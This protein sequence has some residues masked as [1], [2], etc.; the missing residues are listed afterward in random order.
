MF[1]H[2]VWMFLVCLV[3]ITR[4]HSTNLC[5]FASKVLDK[6]TKQP[7]TASLISPRSVTRILYTHTCKLLYRLKSSPNKLLL[8][9]KEILKAYIPIKGDRSEILQAAFHMTY[10]IM[11]CPESGGL[12]TCRWGRLNQLLY[13]S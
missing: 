12:K 1:F 6:T 9:K 11:C 4:K 7:K 5:K 13:L 2:V 10:D 8:E 3:D